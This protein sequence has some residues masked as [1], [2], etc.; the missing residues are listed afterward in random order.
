MRPSPAE[1]ADGLARILRDTVAPHIGDPHAATQLRQVIAVLG[2]IDWNDSAFALLAADQRL[3]DLLS[4]CTSWIDD[5]P[6]RLGSFSP[7]RLEPG[8][9]PTSFSEAAEHHRRHRQMLSTF[10]DELAG[11]RVNESDGASQPIVDRIGRALAGLE[12]TQP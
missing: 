8:P 12:A 7:I 10:I 3:M 1:A 5:A 2:Q 4:N 11:W 9:A 6:A